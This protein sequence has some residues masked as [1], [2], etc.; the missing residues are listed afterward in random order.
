VP[1][2]RRKPLHERLA[3]EGGLVDRPPGGPPPWDHAGVHGVARPRRWDAVA[4]V[5]AP[6]LDREEREFVLLADGTLLGDE[7][8]VALAE[9]VALR[10][11]FRAQAVHRG[12][13]LWAVGANRIEVVELKEDPGGESIE[14]AVHQGERTLLVDGARVFGSIPALEQL[15]RGDGVVHAER[16]DDTL[17]EVSVAQL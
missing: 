10:P 1:F 16:L 13:E 5:E 14:L 15:L 12:G 11:P 7:S 9:A 8:D 4:T 2:R 6:G 3:E 17:W